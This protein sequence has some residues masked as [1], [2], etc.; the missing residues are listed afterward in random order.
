MKP[1]MEPL[2]KLS[3]KPLTGALVEP[4]TE[5]STEPLMETSMKP[6][7]EPSTE[8]LKRGIVCLEPNQRGPYDGLG[9]PKKETKLRILKEKV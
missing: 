2:T 3:I 1:S 7:L 8:T 9:T 5:P 6:A 4:S